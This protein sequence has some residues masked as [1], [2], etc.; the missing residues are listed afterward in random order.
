[1]EL[2]LG[3]PTAH[4]NP[5]PHPTHRS[6]TATCLHIACRRIPYFQATSPCRSSRHSTNSNV[7]HQAHHYCENVQH[8][9][10]YKVN[11]SKNYS[12]CNVRGHF[13]VFRTH[14][15]PRDPQVV[16]CFPP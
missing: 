15:H 16:P 13:G 12:A 8:H 7:F 14:V 11:P 1:M 10:R 2:G 6:C 3:H 9:I 5:P 4:T